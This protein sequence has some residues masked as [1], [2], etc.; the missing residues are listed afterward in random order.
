MQKFET[1]SIN[2]A[3]YLTTILDFPAVRLDDTT[4]RVVFSFANYEIAAIAA[5]AYENG[6]ECSAKALLTMK[7]YLFRKIREVVG[8]G[9]R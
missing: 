9:G 8:R 5:R 4:R 1:S 3:S 7:G 6:A 2:L